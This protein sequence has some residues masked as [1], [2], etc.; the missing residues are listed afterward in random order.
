MIIFF[1][2]KNARGFSRIR[3]LDTVDESTNKNICRPTTDT[4]THTHTK[5]NLYFREKQ[6]VS[7]FRKVRECTIL[8]TS[9]DRGWVGAGSVLSRSDARQVSFLLHELGLTSASNLSQIST[10][11]Q[12]DGTRFLVQFE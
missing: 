2:A 7:I 3:Q 11:I 10:N 1:K 4:H 8:T 6:T 12:Q 9:R 5:I